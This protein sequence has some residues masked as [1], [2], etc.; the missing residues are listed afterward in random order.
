MK[1][2][3]GIIGIVAVLAILWMWLPSGRRAVAEAAYPV[4][5]LIVRMARAVRCR[6]GAVF[7][8]V[9]VAGENRRLRL[10]VDS[11]GMVRSDNDA[12]HAENARL[13]RLLG[14]AGDASP[15]NE[16]IAARVLGRGGAAGCADILRIGRGSLDGVKCGS[17]VAVPDG[18]V[19]IVDSVTPRTATVRILSDPEVKVSCIVETGDESSGV[20]FGIMSGGRSLAV[21]QDAI[22][23]FIYVPSPLHLRHLK[24]SVSIPPR[25][26]IVTSGRGGVYPRGLV[27]GYLLD[28]TH[29]D[30]SRLEREGNVVPAVDFSALEDVFVR[31]ED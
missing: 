27:V 9:S 10:E 13:R 7:N 26:R 17:A 30:E 1:G 14:M 8:S 18:L 15:T 2:K 22:G 11:L 19:G 23:N 29:E 3:Y 25:S 20:V 16:W 5:N 21:A 24:R 31:R 6:V 28:E 4:E 12:L